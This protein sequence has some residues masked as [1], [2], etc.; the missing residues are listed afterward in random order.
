M[1]YFSELLLLCILTFI[2]SVLL[3]NKFN[4]L[5][6]R[7]DWTCT[8]E[9]VIKETLPREWECVQYSKGKDGD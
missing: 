6:H 9:Q 4:H 1:R 3:T 5:I 2:F 8:K 7:S